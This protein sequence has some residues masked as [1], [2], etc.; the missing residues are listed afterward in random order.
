MG[1]YIF[2]SPI[3]RV[4]TLPDVWYHEGRW[5]ANVRP[6]DEKSP[7]DEP[8]YDEPGYDGLGYDEA[9]D[10]EDEDEDDEPEDDESK[11]KKPRPAFVHNYQHDLESLCW[12]AL[13]IFVSRIGRLKEGNEGINAIAAACF[14]GPTSVPNR[15]ALILGQKEIQDF[16][17]VPKRVRGLSQRFDR[18]FE[19]FAYHYQERMNRG[20][21]TVDK[22]YGACHALV[23]DF[24]VE[25]SGPAMPWYRQALLAIPPPNPHRKAIG[26]QPSTRNRPPPDDG[27]FQPESE[28]V[29]IANPT[30]PS[31]RSATCGKEEEG[32]N[33][34]S[35]CVGGSS[36]RK[37]GAQSRRVVTTRS[38]S[39]KSRQT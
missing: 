6:K 23:H 2:P 32:G 19:K 10:E 30:T 36:R 1:Y 37:A 16:G 27:D 22:S 34:S 35:I 17:S 28:S 15:Q 31:S 39:K 26:N 12:L 33:P 24:L 4:E 14:S 5:T 20:E 3:G 9:Q 25:V 7:N 8:A 21:L 18:L 13:Y 11:N 29:P 38:K